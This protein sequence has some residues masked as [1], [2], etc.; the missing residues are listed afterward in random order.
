[1][2]RLEIAHLFDTNGRRSY[3]ANTNHPGVIRQFLRGQDRDRSPFL[4]S[5]PRPQLADVRVAAT[6][7]AEDA[8]PDGDGLENVFSRLPQI[9]SIPQAV[10]ILS[11]VCKP[12]S[13]TAI[14]RI[15]NFWTFPVTV[16]GNSS[17]NLT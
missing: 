6:A 13:A 9:A 7:G 3:A 16:M 1:M 8:G 11:A 10:S 12:S 17:V 5:L 2:V 14:S 15:R 4:D